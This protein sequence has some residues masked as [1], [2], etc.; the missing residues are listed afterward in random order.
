MHIGVINVSSV[1][2]N[3]FG[4]RAPSLGADNRETH[5]IN[6]ARTGKVLV[7]AAMSLL[8]CVSVSS[9]ASQ[10]KLQSTQYLGLGLSRLSINSDHPSINNQSIA[11]IS[12]LWGLRN[13]QHVFEVSIAGGNGVDVGPTPDIYYPEDSADY[14]AITL[15]YQYLFTDFEFAKD[16]F[17]YLGLGYSYNSFN[18]QTYVYDHSG[19]GL[20]IIGGLILE[21]EKNWA[22]NGSL[23]RYSFSGTRLLFTE[24][25]YANYD[26]EIYELAII[27]EYRF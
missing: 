5:S 2:R 12:L 21:I 25:G 20:T 13:Q 1:V 10:D 11:G 6:S 26:S 22:V 4:H 24:G 8:F 18:W 9:E 3:I 27:L 14:G 17:P 19:D 16:V 15:S 7:L 23:R